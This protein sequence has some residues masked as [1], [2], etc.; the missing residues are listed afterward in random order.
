MPDHVKITTGTW[1]VV[2]D[3]E[4]ALFLENEGYDQDYNFRVRRIEEQDNPPARDQATDA[5]GRRSDGPSGHFSAMEP[6]DWHQIERYVSRRISPTS[7]T[8]RPIAAAT[9]A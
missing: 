3:G 8:P 7:S 2:A 6:T 5:P 9:T 1:I 4:K